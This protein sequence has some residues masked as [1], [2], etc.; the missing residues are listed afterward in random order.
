MTQPRPTWDE[1]TAPAY[2]A[3]L[4]AVAGLIALLGG[5]AVIVVMAERPAPDS[6]P[7]RPPTP[8]SKPRPTTTP[9]QPAVVRIAV[10]G[11]GAYDPE[12]DGSENDSNAALATDGSRVTAWKSER[13]RSTFTKSGV[14]LVVDAGRPVRGKQVVVVTESPGYRAQVRVGASAK[15]PFVTASETRVTTLR[16]TF[17]LRPRSGRYLMLWITSMPETGAAAVNEITLTAAG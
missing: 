3:R 6:R 16:T 14:G 13:Y 4:L 12:G 10:T 9:A 11:V 17:T 2:R 8:V 15:G 1:R 7:S 5:M